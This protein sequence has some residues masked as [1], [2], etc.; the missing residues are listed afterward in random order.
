MLPARLDD[1]RQRVALVVDLLDS[2]DDVI[3]V[4][5]VPSSTFCVSHTPSLA[6]MRLDVRQ[7]ERAKVDVGARQR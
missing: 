4:G 5:R 6:Q 2:A 1:A 3:H 7:R